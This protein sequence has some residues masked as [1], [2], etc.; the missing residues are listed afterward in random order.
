MSTCPLPAGGVTVIDDELLRVK[1]TPVPPNDTALV[2][3]PG[4]LKSA[5]WIVTLGGPPLRVV[6]AE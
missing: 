5:P 4:P 3:N 2:V 1:G 6:C